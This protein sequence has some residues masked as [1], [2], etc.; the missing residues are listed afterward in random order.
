MLK[1]EHLYRP[2]RQ[3]EK[4]MAINYMF[5]CIGTVVGLWMLP[6]EGKKKII[7][8]LILLILLL[9]SVTYLNMSL[10]YVIFFSVFLTSV[11]TDTHE[12][13]V[14][15]IPLYLM[16]PISLFLFYGER[17]YI[18][19]VFMIL[20]PMYRKSKRLQFYFGEGDLWILLFISMAF[21]RDVFFTLF[22]ASG[23][24]IIAALFLKKK[25][26]YFVPFLFI[27]LILAQFEVINQ[28]LY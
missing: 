6:K 2:V 26:I 1:M 9:G 12:G 19:G 5:P 13:L 7:V 18:A 27:G 24:G 21:G 28:I 10:S 3:A 22:Y 25:E 20:I 16:A 15:D 11:V 8:T 4:S 23:L 17:S 14:Y